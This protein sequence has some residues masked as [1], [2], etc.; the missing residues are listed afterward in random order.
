MNPRAPTT[1]EDYLSGL[2]P[3]VAG[4][5]SEIRKIIRSAAP[6]AVETIRYG[7][8][9]FQ[10]GGETLIHVGA[11][12]RHVGI[13][14]PVRDPELADRVAPY[15]GEAGNLRLPL[16]QPIPYDLIADVV[17]ARVRRS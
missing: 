13:Y 16:D 8:P 17:R 5:L 4:I 2:T 9:T 14:P 10:L 15:R 7:M 1:I 6:E 3:E 12:K 11:F